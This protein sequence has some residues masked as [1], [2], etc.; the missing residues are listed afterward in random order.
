MTCSLKSTFWGVDLQDM[1]VK[2]LLSAQTQH[3]RYP[4]SVLTQFD[5]SWW[6]K[7]EETREMGKED[8]SKEKLRN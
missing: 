8:E 5:R 2:E 6:L 3:L 7:L 4:N 1:E